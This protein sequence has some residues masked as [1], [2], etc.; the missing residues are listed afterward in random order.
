[1]TLDLTIPDFLT[2][3]F[4]GGAV[5][6]G[7]VVGVALLRRARGPEGRRGDAFLGG[8]LVA[9]ASSLLGT[10]VGSLG[11]YRLSAHFYIMPFIYTLSLGP[12]LYGT[13]RARTDPAWSLGRRDRVHAIL[14]GVQVVL[15]LSMGLAPLAV[16]D[17][18]WQSPVGQVWGTIETW[19]LP[20]Q[21]GAY[22][23]AARGVLRRSEAT[24]EHAWLGRLVDGTLA[25]AGVVLVTTVLYETGLTFLP[26][27]VELGA[28][29]SYAGLLYW[30]ALTCWRHAVAPP[31]VPPPATRRET[32]GMTAGTLA[33]HTESV[34]GHVV[35]E[36]PYLDPELTL[37]TLAEQVGLGEKELSYVLNAGLGVAYAD[38]ING[39][40]V[41]EAERRLRDPAS[42]EATVLEIGL[43]SGFASKAT[44]NR[45][46]K[47][48]TGQ[49]P[50]AYRAAASAPLTAS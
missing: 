39:L 26:D 4:A 3:L 25:I 40:R 45:A 20:V 50:T 46:F 38:Y 43:A 21:F 17:W 27:W 48:A 33:G 24:P 6:L 41:A 28:A 2:A 1:M 23:L 35:A 31:P 37:G 18:Y 29:L 11:L 15:S 13:V 10:L 47:R 49:T 42:E 44:F 8:F 16:K 12:L 36:R 22:L 7:L 9:G 19:T 14:P 34:R 32:Y 5:L 30:I